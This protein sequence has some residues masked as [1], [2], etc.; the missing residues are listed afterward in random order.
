MKFKKRR[1]YNML[2][3]YVQIKNHEEGT[4]EIEKINKLHSM[5]LVITIECEFGEKCLDGDLTFKHHNN[6]NNVAACMQVYNFCENLLK[7]S[8]EE[9]P[10]NSYAN[11]AIY[12][13]FNVLDL[14]T[15]LSIY[16]LENFLKI[17]P[18]YST[19]LKNHKPFIETISQAD[20]NGVHTIDKNLY[21]S[22]MVI[23]YH[24][25]ANEVK[26]KFEKDSNIQLEK[27]INCIE[28]LL[29]N[30]DFV[31]EYFEKEEARKKE[32]ESMLINQSKHGRLFC[33]DGIFCGADYET[34][35]F[36]VSFNKRFKAV[37][38]SF[39]DSGEKYN[40]IEIIQG[41]FGQDAGGHPGIAGT[42]RNVEFKFEDALKV[43]KK[44]NAIYGLN[45]VNNAYDVE[46]IEAE[47]KELKDGCFVIKINDC[48]YLHFSPLTKY[49]S[50]YNIYDC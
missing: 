22:K 19:K 13:L 23:A 12:I 16:L 18:S 2:Y 35:D 8:C 36:I 27:G 45:F 37:T 11:S 10:Y 20:C 1:R 15:L 3:N 31:T 29:I 41:I 4:K 33:T 26:L 32:V 46:K 9:N 30:S 25:W 40:A 14:D 28:K 24:N 43:F 48:E 42:P 7:N 6:K 21:E 39:K 47:P 44:V 38:L 50:A 49:N 34:K 17:N 5:S